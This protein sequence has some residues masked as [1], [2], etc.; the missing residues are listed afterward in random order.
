MVTGAADA[1]AAL[2][3]IAANEGVQ[4]QSKR[5]AYLLSMLG[6]DQVIVLINKMDLVDFSESVYQQIEEEY[7]DF[8]GKLGIQ[9]LRFIPIA[10]REGLNLVEPLNGVAK[11][12]SGP[13]LMRALDRLPAPDVG[14]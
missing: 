11:W 7:R 6:V 8:L 14:G 4:E 13:T 3:L 5:H 2:L 10:A 9:P 12:Y 1:D